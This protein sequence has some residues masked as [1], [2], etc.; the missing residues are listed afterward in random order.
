MDLYSK[1]CFDCP[2]NSTHCWHPECVTGDG[3]KR[4][5]V[6]ANRQMPG[7]AVAVC[8]GDTVVT[9][10][11]NNLAMETTTMHFHGEHFED[12]QYMDGTPFI[13]QC[14]IYPMTTFRYIF[15]AKVTGTMFFHSHVL[16]QRGDG[17]FGTY[18][19]RRASEEDPN[20][21]Q[22]D[23]DL[24]E[25]SIHVQEWFH[26]QTK[27]M[28]ALHHWDTG[29]NRSLTTSWSMGEVERK[30]LKTK[31]SRCLCLK[32]NLARGTGSGRFRPDLPCVQLKYR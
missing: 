22:Y 4:G 24:T 19:V 13:T 21:D 9:D 29:K 23:V 12:N 2:K 8:K 16:H 28:Y 26:K 32:F 7:P 17:L 25:H 14:P 20:F 11:I 3:I 10:I 6:T 18:I 1:A 5:I 31:K 15:K 27:E 30:L